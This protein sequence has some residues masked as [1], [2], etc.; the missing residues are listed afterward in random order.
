MLALVI[1]AKYHGLGGGVIG[2]VRDVPDT[3]VVHYCNTGQQAATNW[4]LLSEVLGRRGSTLYDGSMAEWTEQ[5]D[6]PVE[7]G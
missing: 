7:V 1:A 4:F 3:P 2:T 6:R 5:P